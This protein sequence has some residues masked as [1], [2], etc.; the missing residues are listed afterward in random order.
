MPDQ[1]NT[2]LGIVKKY[3]TTEWP[4]VAE[5]KTPDLQP[6]PSTERPDG[7]LITH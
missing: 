4:S 5:I 6:L 7:V 3:M 2:V 1:S